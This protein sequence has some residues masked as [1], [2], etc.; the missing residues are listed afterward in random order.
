H[1]L[2]VDASGNLYIADSVNR[3]VRKVSVSGIITTIAG[4][5]PAGCPVTKPP[6]PP[7]STFRGVA[8]DPSGN[9]WIADSLNHRVRFVNL[10][11][12]RVTVTGKK[13]EPGCIITIAGNGTNASSGDGGPPDEAAVGQPV[14]LAFDATGNLYITSRS[15]VRFIKL[16]KPFTITTVAGDEQIFFSG[17]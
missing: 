3:K 6:E 4:P 1:G 10:S 9:L 13:V 7:L 5:V 11:D 14:G 17:D 12:A 16:E 15:R 8:I 2:A